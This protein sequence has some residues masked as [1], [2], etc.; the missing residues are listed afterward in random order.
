MSRHNEKSE[1][2]MGEAAVTMVKANI[3]AYVV[4]AIFIL[5]GSMI[6]TYTKANESV[7]SIIV[8]LGII[9]SAFLA[10]FDTAKIEDRN[11][12]KWGAIGGVCYFVIFLILGTMINK[13]TNVSPGRIFLIAIVVFITSMIAGMISVNSNA[14]VSRRR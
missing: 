6:L 1:I 14:V 10:G 7:E 13:L 12:Y 11:G 4:T 9:A 3:M 8:M 5:L 2:N